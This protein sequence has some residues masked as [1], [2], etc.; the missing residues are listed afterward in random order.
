V[1]VFFLSLVDCLT[2]GI[3][4]GRVLPW[5]MDEGEIKPRWEEGPASL[6]VVQILGHP[7]V[8]EIPMIIQDLYCMFSSFQNV[9]PF[10]Q[11]SDDR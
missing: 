8:C 11:S 10:L 4:F 7:K 6:L 3:W 1:I 2:E 5:S 9:P